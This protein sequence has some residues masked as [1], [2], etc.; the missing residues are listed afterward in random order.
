MVSGLAW[1]VEESSQL[2]SEKTALPGSPHPASLRQ[3]SN[4]CKGRESGQTV[5]EDCQSQGSFAPPGITVKMR[6]VKGSSS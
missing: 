3:S 1:K 4:G 2:G 5:G 6:A